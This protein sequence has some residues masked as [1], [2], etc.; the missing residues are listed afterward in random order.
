MSA[1][2]KR[3]LKRL[4]MTA[5]KK[6]ETCTTTLVEPEVD[7]TAGQ[8]QAFLISKVEVEAAGHVIV[9]IRAFKPV[10]PIAYRGRVIIVPPKILAVVEVR[11]LLVG[12]GYH[13]H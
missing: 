2:M 10:Q 9:A 12:G 3:W 1:T 4:E 13:A 5:R 8:W 6:Y 7:A 11:P